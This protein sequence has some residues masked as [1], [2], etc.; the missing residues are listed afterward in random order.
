MSIDAATL[1]RH[2]FRMAKAPASET[3]RLLSEW[4]EKNNL[5][6]QRA[7]DTIGVNLRQIQYWL[8]GGSPQGKN[9]DKLATAMG[10]HEDDFYPRP[11]PIKA[12]VEGRLEVLE[13]WAG[14]AF[15]DLDDRL[16]AVERLLFAQ[17]DDG[18]A[19]QA[20]RAQLVESLLGG[21]VAPVM[22]Q[23]RKP[24]AAKPASKATKA[25]PTRGRSRRATPRSNGD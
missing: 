20:A 1:P 9:V 7:A 25:P 23:S 24:R 5:T 11:D 6:Q 15:E 3:A 17:P 21:E 22:R 10:L 12:D 18:K 2:A 19:A 14:E 16:N 13:G 8:R 4:I